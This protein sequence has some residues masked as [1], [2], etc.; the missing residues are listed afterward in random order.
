MAKALTSRVVKAISLLGSTQMA[1]MLCS[2]VR[3]KA[4]AIWVGPIGV[5]LMGVFGQTLEFMGTLTQMDIR[6]SAVR[7]VASRPVSQRGEIIGIVRRVSRAM[8]ILGLVLVLLFAPLFSHF[9]FGSDEYS[10]S[11]RILSLALFFQAL[12]GSELIVL[13]AEGRYR[14]IALSSLSAAIVGLV[15]ALVLFKTMGLNGVALVLVSYSIFTW[16]FTARHSRGFR[17]E[18]SALSLR[19]CFRRSRRFIEM[20][21]YLVISGLIATGVSMAFM[22]IFE[23]SAGATELG[24]YQAGN[25]MLIRYVGVFFTAITMEFYPRLSASTPRHNHAS[26]IMTHQART[27]ML[28]FFPCAALA[29][30]LTPWLI[31]LLYDAEYMPMAPYFILGM[32]GMMMRPASMILSYS[33]I[34]FNKV[35]P[36]LFTEVTSALVGLGLN[37]AGFLLGGFPGLGLATIAWYLFDLMIIYVTCRV[38]DTPCFGT[39]TLIMALML[40]IALSIAS[41]IM[42]KFLIIC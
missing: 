16:L 3:M 27:C 9:F 38:T 5:A 36:Y 13:Q 15:M 21:F 8:G 31:R 11:F 12:Q 19:E 22:A 41:I 20:G 2:V 34:A 35:K 18:A 1:N 17:S 6:V 33:F 4:L 40:S 30:L 7:D 14:A 29:V 26:L 24:Y 23:R 10:M 42:L 32:I 39:R 25:T 28:L 37:V